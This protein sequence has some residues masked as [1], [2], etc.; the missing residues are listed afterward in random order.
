MSAFT[1]AKSKGAN[2]LNQGEGVFG[3][4]VARENRACRTTEVQCY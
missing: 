4:L 2:M 3:Y 1:Q